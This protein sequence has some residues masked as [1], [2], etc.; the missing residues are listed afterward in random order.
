[1]YA[2][3]KLIED[4]KAM[5]IQNQVMTFGDAFL[6]NK[7]ADELEALRA[8]RNDYMNWHIEQ[9]KQI[10]E[11]RAELQHVKDTAKQA[12]RK[13]Q[14][15]TF[16]WQEECLFDCNDLLDSINALPFTS[17][18]PQPITLEEIMGGG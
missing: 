1:M 15:T 5:D 3:N 7:A 6:P 8:Q 16:N 18:D 11:L 4:C 2:L 17:P 10:A 13:L 9:G 12:Q 14:A